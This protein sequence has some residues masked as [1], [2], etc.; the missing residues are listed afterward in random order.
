MWNLIVSQKSSVHFL[1][2]GFQWLRC[3]MDNNFTKFR[4]ILM[5]RFWDIIVSLHCLWKS[6]KQRFPLVRMLNSCAC[7]GVTWYNK[8]DENKINYY[9][10]L[11]GIF[12]SL[13]SHFFLKIPLAAYLLMIYNWNVNRW[14][15]KHFYRRK[16]RGS[17]F[18][19]RSHQSFV[20]TE[21]FACVKFLS[22]PQRNCE[23]TVSEKLC[24]ATLSIFRKKK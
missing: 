4:Q 20:R 3:D 13:S 22:V 9:R 12:L 16:L 24:S 1:F 17:N 18:L 14:G 8:S 11:L 23:E 5:S 7:A 15:M 21:T 10:Q 2:S 19:F 6:T